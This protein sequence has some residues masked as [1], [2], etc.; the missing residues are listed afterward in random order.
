MQRRLKVTYLS[1][2][3]R[4]R[5][6]RPCGPLYHSRGKVGADELGR[7]YLWDFEADGGYNFIALSPEQIVSMELTEDS[8]AI[9]EVSSLGKKTGKI[10]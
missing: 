6:V 4:E 3:R 8:F 5:L 7:Y 10:T 9:D 2:E 1:N